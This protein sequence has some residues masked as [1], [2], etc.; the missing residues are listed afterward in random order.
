MNLGGG[1]GALLTSEVDYADLGTHGGRALRGRVE[2]RSLRIALGQREGMRLRAG[3]ARA[4]AVEVEEADGR[5]Y[6]LPL[7]APTDPWLAAARR[8]LL[9]WLLSTLAVGLA[10]RATRARR[11]HPTPA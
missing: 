2:R 4:V 6:E 3:R 7:Q 1:A 5:R 11:P 8:L 10:R 9:V